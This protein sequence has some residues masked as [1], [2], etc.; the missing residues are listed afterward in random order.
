MI[1]IEEVITIHEEVIRIFGGKLGLRDRNLPDSA[2]HRPYASLSDQ[3]LY[4]SL[5]EKAAA[6]LES[7]VNNHPFLDGNKRVGYVL[8][9]LTL[10]DHGYDINATQQEKFELVMSVSRGDWQFENIVEWLRVHTT[11]L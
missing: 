6:I 7:I 11:H 9:R 1:S 4:S 5:E 10:L 8:C 3:E 2:I